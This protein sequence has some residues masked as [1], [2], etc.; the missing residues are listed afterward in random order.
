MKEAALLAI[1]VTFGALA[2]AIMVLR[3]MMLWDG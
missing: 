2:I 3:L 1:G